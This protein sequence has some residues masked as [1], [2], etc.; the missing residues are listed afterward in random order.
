MKVKIRRSDRSTD[1][2]R[3]QVMLAELEL[4]QR[5]LRVGTIIGRGP[6]PEGGEIVKAESF[7]DLFPRQEKK[8]KPKKNETNHRSRGDLHR[9]QRGV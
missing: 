1:V 8:R 7:R 4:L 6:V 5:A 3:G 9:H 2:K